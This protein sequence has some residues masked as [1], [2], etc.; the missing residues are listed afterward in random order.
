MS[1]SSRLLHVYIH[2]FLSYFIIILLSVVSSALSLSECCHL[3]LH[4]YTFGSQMEVRR[5]CYILRPEVGLPAHRQVGPGIIE[6]LLHCSLRVQLCQ[7]GPLKC[8]VMCK[9]RA[10]QPP[11]LKVSSEGVIFSRHLIPWLLLWRKE[12]M[13]SCG[14]SR[15]PPP[16][17]NAEQ[18]AATFIWNIF[19]SLS[20]AWS[21]DSE[22]L[23]YF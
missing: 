21:T 14:R 16:F 11:G 15:H 22:A 13:V 18:L 23:H 12:Q 19:Q 1:I 4:T 8:V 2:V 9:I 7:C 6:S 3:H 17:S 10:R 20:S 5:R